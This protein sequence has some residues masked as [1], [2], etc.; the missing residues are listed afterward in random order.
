M[1]APVKIRMAAARRH[2]MSKMKDCDLLFSN[3]RTV[4]KLSPSKRWCVPK[5][6]TARY[7]VRCSAFARGGLGFPSVPWRG[8]C[9]IQPQNSAASLVQGRQEPNIALMQKQSDA[10]MSNRESPESILLDMRK[11]RRRPCNTRCLLQVRPR[12]PEDSATQFAPTWV[13]RATLQCK[14]ARMHCL[15]SPLPHHRNDSW[16]PASPANPGYGAKAMLQ[17]NDGDAVLIS[18]TAPASICETIPPNAKTNSQATN[19][20]KTRRAK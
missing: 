20:F 3:A 12:I 13:G 4:P 16:D 8:V 7:E 17:D 15:L 18:G 10:V 6:R 5:L 14:F 2:C 9:P 19:E 1:R 11:L